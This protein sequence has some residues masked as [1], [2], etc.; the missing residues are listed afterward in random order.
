MGD[1]VLGYPR[2]GLQPKEAGRGKDYRYR[3][4][5]RAPAAQEE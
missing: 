3:Q 2:P 1:V 5:S 4:A